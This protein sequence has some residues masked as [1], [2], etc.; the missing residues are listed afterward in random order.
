MAAFTPNW[1][2]PSNEMSKPQS[3]QMTAKKQ[4][5]MS[6]G[7]DY[8]MGPTPEQNQSSTHNHAKAGQVDFSTPTFEASAAA[9]N[10]GR[11][12]IVESNFMCVNR[13][14]PRRNIFNMENIS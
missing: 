6:D 2:M 8:G 11:V 4:M 13:R 5:N 14:K 3:Q 10:S 12:R 1:H 9:Q 7:G